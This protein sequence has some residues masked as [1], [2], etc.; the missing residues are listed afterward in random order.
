M[1]GKLA[2]DTAATNALKGNFTSKTVSPPLQTNQRS[3]TYSF[4]ALDGYA[5][6]SSNRLKAKLEKSLLDFFLTAGFLV[7][8]SSLASFSR[9]GIFVDFFNSLFSGFDSFL[10]LLIVSR[11]DASKNVV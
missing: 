2:D 11:H 9:S 3:R 6:N 8:S 5:T 4:A 10:D 1:G 7:T